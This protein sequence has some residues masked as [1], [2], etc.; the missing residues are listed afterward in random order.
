MAD[1]FALFHYILLD[2]K[3]GT[4]LPIATNAKSLYRIK[5]FT[6]KLESKLYFFAGVFKY[7]YNQVS[8][9]KLGSSANVAEMWRVKRTWYVN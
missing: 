9:R 1:T 5:Y 2:P 6:Y 3:S 7:K 8:T 4:H